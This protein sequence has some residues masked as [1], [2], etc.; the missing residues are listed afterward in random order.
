MNIVKLLPHHS[1]KIWGYEQWQFSTH[2]NGMSKVEQTG[3]CLKEYLQ[4]SLPILIKYIVANQ[5]LSVQVHPDD[6]YARIHT[7][8]LGK[9]ECW[10]IT[11]ADQDAQLILGLKPGI[12]AEKL[13]SI[14]ANNEL[15]SYLEFISVEAGDM[16]YIPAGTVHAIT[17]GLKLIEIQQSSDTTYRLYDWGRNRETHLTESL[18][19]IDYDAV[20][21]ARKIAADDFKSLTTP[22]FT[23]KKQKITHSINFFED[24]PTT[25]S[26]VE[27]MLTFVYD[28]NKI[29]ANACETLYIKA[30]TKVEI[31][32]EAT[33]LIT[34]W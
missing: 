25:I 23:V 17:G 9:T 21:G 26:L 13:T 27:G 8:D 2:E 28:G 33:T 30:K 19:V 3:Q 24:Q 11:E 10:Y 4:E 14:I 32:G 20:N 18:A 5:T 12:N 1:E 34:A 31:M 15:E 16:L 7:N 29:T 22:Y 6:N